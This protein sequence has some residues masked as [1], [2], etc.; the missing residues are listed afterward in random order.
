VAGLFE[1]SNEPS[2]SIK[3]GNFLTNWATVSLIVSFLERNRL[4]G[5]DCK[6]YS[7]RITKMMK[8]III[9]PCC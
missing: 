4:H 1:N 8:Q 3:E 6:F 5:V 7:L 2:D 9:S